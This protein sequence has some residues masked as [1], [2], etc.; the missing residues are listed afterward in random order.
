MT[1]LTLLANVFDFQNGA[2]KIY[3]LNKMML[4]GAS[5]TTN[6][7]HVSSKKIF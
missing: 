4:Y 3:Y 6:S 2:I 7:I 5:Y 1:I